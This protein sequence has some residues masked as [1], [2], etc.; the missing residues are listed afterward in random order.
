MTD[1]HARVEELLSAM[2]DGAA[3]PE[4][5]TLVQRHL[6]TCAQCRA[7]AAAFDQID[8]QVRRYLMATPVPEMV[9]PWRNEPLVVVAPRRSGS[10]GHWRATTVGLALIFALL[11]A[12]AA[13]TFYQRTTPQEAQVGQ[14][15]AIAA[16]AVAV[17]ATRESATSFSVPAASQAPASAAAAAGAAAPSAARAAAAAPASAAASSAAASSVAPRPSAAASAAA[18]SAAASSAGATG[19]GAASAAPSAAVSAAASAAPALPPAVATPAP[20]PTAA[21]STK[22][23]ATTDSAAFNPT[24]AYRL[25]TATALT[26]CRPAC[27]EQA[28]PPDLLRRVV[29]ALDQ[30]LPP[31]PPVPPS[32]VTIPYVTLRFTLA[33]GQMVDIGYYL[34]INQLQLP[35]GR[36]P[37]VAPAELVAALA[38]VVAPR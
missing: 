28:Q 8:R 15:T 37:V 35:D 18:A 27:D 16:Q 22:S 13:L 7:T 34:Q 36:P 14:A 10:P 9:S 33:D 21:P 25:D 5:V 19:G 31:A 30:P 3:T 2:Q 38:G 29:A 23:T 26:I 4:E 32:T 17:A 12:G 20:T 6:A 11:F 24:Q 1:E